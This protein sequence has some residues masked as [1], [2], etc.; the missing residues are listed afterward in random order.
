MN[1]K[2]VINAYLKNASASD[3]WAKYIPIIKDLPVKTLLILEDNEGRS[4]VLKI[5]F[6][7]RNSTEVNVDVYATN[8]IVS[9]TSQLPTKYLFQLDIE[10]TSIKSR[11]PWTPKLAPLTINWCMSGWYKAMAFGA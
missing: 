3:S 7:R 10:L 5:N 1:K 9:M 6:L 11:K 2:R 8:T 4:Y